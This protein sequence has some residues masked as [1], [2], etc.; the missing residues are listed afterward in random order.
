MYE[1]F[2][3]WMNLRRDQLA[4]DVDGRDEDV[5]LELS[6]AHLGERLVGVVEG[7]DLVLALVLRSRTA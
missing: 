2:S 7:R 4:Q 5:E 3:G 6:R 1:W